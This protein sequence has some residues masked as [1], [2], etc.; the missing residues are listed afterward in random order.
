MWP[1]LE[2][3]AGLVGHGVDDAQQ[4]VGEGHAGQALAVVHPSRQP[5][6]AVKGAEQVLLHDVDGLE[7]QGSVNTVW[8]VDT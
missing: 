5:M 7:G 4:G 3:R 6:S 1:P 2:G 8:R